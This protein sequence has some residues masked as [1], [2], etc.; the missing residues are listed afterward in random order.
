MPWCQC[1]GL[2]DTYCP[3][4]ECTES[5]CKGRYGLP[6]SDKPVNF[7]IENSKPV[8]THFNVFVYGSLKSGGFLNSH[9]S[10][11]EFLGEAVTAD[12]KF[13][14]VSIN[15]RFP[16]VTDGICGVL[17]EVYRVDTATLASLDIAEGVPH[18]YTR[19]T[20]KVDGFDEV[21]MYKLSKRFD[22][23]YALEFG[24]RVHLDDE[25]DAFY[26]H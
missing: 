16:G 20:I 17:G 1:P 12:K 22:R 11:A 19:E 21:F 13:C 10:K 26:W 2:T 8:P 18:M 14:M 4:E 5:F 23:E 25:F 7:T 6:V 9:L 15:D 3:D 24:K